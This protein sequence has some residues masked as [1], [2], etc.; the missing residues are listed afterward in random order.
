VLIEPLTRQQVEDYLTQH[1]DV[2]RVVRERLDADPEL[3]EILNSPLM[4]S[5]VTIAFPNGI[6]SFQA[7]GTFQERRIWLW[8]KYIERMFV[9]KRNN[10]KYDRDSTMIWL[11]RLAWQ[12]VQ[13]NLTVYFIERMQQDWLPEQQHRVYKVSSVLVGIVAG[14]LSFGL[15]FGLSGLLIG[16]VVGILL[17]G[18]R[19][20]VIYGMIFGGLVGVLGVLVGGGIGV[21]GGA[22]LTLSDTI[23]IVEKY[24]WSWSEAKSGLRRWSKASSELN[25]VL[26]GFVGGGGEY[27]LGAL[28]AG[29]S[30]E[31]MPTKV[32]PNQG[33]LF[34]LRNALLVGKNLGFVSLVIGLIGTLTPSLIVLLLFR[35]SNP[36]TYGFSHLLISTAVGISVGLIGGLIGVLYFGGNT[37]L[38]HYILRWF[39]YRNNLIPFRDLIPWLD[40]CVDRLFLRRVGGG[41][42]FIHRLLMGHFAE[43]NDTLNKTGKNSQPRSALGVQKFD[44]TSRKKAIGIWWVLGALA[45]LFIGFIIG[46]LIRLCLGQV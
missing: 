15:V 4:L 34:S 43:M 41:Y 7:T 40:Y 3:M 18:M 1:G 22:L 28:M 29:L 38:K 39:L 11:S 6:S 36:W 12:M 24:R 10:P 33:I 44:S 14:V 21:Q 46:L 16:G 32:I 13:C 35:P 8:E 37:V 31:E 20:G 42:I 25:P 9:R 5:V 17:G 23:E 30:S 26:R 19:D 45:V 27:K 2:L